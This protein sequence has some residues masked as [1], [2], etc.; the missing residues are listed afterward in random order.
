[1][2]KVIELMD[3]IKI[4]LKCIDKIKKVVSHCSKINIMQ[5]KWDKIRRKMLQIQ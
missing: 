4:L 1:M 5:I 2:K 3:K